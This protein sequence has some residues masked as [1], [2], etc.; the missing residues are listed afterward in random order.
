MAKRTQKERATVGVSDHW[1][2]AVLMT[3]ARDGSLIDRRRV[4]LVDPGLPK[5][6][7]HHDAQGLPVAEAVALVEQVTRSAHV[8]ASACLDALA[9]SVPATIVGMA[10]RTSPELPETIAERL[11]NYRAQ[12]VADSVMYREALARAAEARGWF[13]HRYDHRHVLADAADALGRG[14]IAELLR[15]TGAALGPPWQKDHQL[16]MAA[17]IA[18]AAR[19]R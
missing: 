9:T 6:P 16:A 12:N 15:K 17:A 2:W 18:A 5:M 10:L 1:G 11:T 7:H 8:Y 13:V 14:S 19:S 3:V 4:E